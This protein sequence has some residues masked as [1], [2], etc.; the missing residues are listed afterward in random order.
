MFVASS[1]NVD[2]F[3]R[4]KGLSR[5]GNQVDIL[6]MH[7]ENLKNRWTSFT[8]RSI[9][10]V[11]RKLDRIIDHAH[12]NVQII[13][14]IKKKEYNL[15]WIEKGLMVK[16]STLKEISSALPTVMIIGYSADDLMNADNTTLVF[17]NT[18]KYYD[19][20]FTTKS[21]NVL[22]LKNLGCKS[23]SFIGNAYE[24]AIHYPMHNELTAAD[25]KYLAEVSFVG[26]YENSRAD[27][28]DKLARN[29]DTEIKIFG[30][31][32]KNNKYG[33]LN[34][35]LI[36]DDYLLGK[37]YAK[38]IC[39]AKINLGFLHKGNRDKQTTRS[40]E[41]PACNGFLLA[42][43]TDE[44][45]ELFEENIE[46]VYFESNDELRDKVKYYLL[47]ENERKTIARHGYERC[48]RSGYSNADRVQEMMSYL[49]N[50]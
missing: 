20:Y 8:W 21:Y 25:K 2:S 50:L 7:P 26:A 16:E 24:P 10:W 36:E 47:H 44:H 34:N 12:I 40:I 11:N 15:L 48:M 19:H 35:L 28:I 38:A 13:Q 46:A 32:W 33:E 22:E 42:E 37:E 23:V 29:I 30:P 31:R 39:S 5:L 17:R 6:D 3:F 18:L 1:L 43:R 4:A 14:S 49:V 27:Y 45:L 41:I 9:N